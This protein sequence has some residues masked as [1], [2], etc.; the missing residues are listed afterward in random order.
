MPHIHSFK[1][2]CQYRTNL[3]SLLE[4]GLAFGCLKE[5][6]QCQQSVLSLSF[7]QG[8]SEFLSS[9]HVKHIWL[10][11]RQGGWTLRKLNVYSLRIYSPWLP[12]PCPFYISW[13]K[14]STNPPRYFA[15]L[16]RKQSESALWYLSSH[17]LYIAFLSCESISLVFSTS[18]MTWSS[19]RTCHFVSAS[20]RSIAPNCSGK[21]P[22]CR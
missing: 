16:R 21:V 13:H 11:S 9:Q 18:I 17:A 19:R 3:H 7:L 12:C 5:R 2:G 6:W 4:S 15:R 14:L 22:I 1:L 8:S 20:A 10:S